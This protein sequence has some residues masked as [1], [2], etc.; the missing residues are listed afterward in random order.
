MDWNLVKEEL[1]RTYKKELFLWIGIVLLLGISLFLCVREYQKFVVNLQKLKRIET[2]YYNQQQE[3][4]KL[5]EKLKSFDLNTRQR[6][7]TTPF[8][9]VYDLKD[10][11]RALFEIGALT[12]A[13]GHF[14]VLRE[15]TLLKGKEKG[16]PE[17]GAPKLKIDGEIVIFINGES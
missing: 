3:I 10:L 7:V 6:I 1:G 17:E 13:K 9:G 11:N 12:Q 8:S 4:M 2:S 14:L 5:K 16:V 15:L